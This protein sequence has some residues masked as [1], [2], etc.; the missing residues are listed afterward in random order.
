MTIAADDL[1]Y[2]NGLVLLADGSTLLVAE[3]EAGRIISFAVAEDGSLSDR[4]L[5]VR[6]TDLDEPVGVYPDGIKLGPDGNFYV[7]L[8][9]AGRVVVASPEGKLVRKIEV[10]SAAAPNL[11]FSED[12]KTI[13]VTAVGDTSAAPY[14]GK[15]YAVD[16]E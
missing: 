14:P 13:F 3:S 1:H 8:Y 15:V 2:A 16:F 6:L 5:F 4:R 11:A 12:G 9:S 10:P 7:G